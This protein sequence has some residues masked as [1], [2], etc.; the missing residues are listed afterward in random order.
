MRE[1]TTNNNNSDSFYEE[2]TS[3]TTTNSA[4][5]KRPHSL[6]F[7][8]GKPGKRRPHLLPVLDSPDIQ[9]LGLATPDIDKFLI[10]ANSGV[11]QTPSGIGYTPKVRVFSFGK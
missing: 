4:G 5:M 11:L 10:N 7:N 6:D 8:T 2:T 9:K 3:N 1:N